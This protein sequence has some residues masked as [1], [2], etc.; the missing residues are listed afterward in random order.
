MVVKILSG[1]YVLG[2]IVFWL[3]WMDF[4]L[5]CRKD[6]DKIP[7]KKSSTISRIISRVTLFLA[8]L[9]PVANFFIGVYFSTYKEK[10]EEAVINHI[11]AKEGAP[12]I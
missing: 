4:I 10:I 9:I 2:I 5:L 11:M 7:L 1:L 8:C 3:G 12:H 6:K